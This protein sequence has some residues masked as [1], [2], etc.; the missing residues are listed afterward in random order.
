[1]INAAVAVFWVNANK[2]SNRIINS[3]KEGVKVTLLSRL[4]YLGGTCRFKMVM[5]AVITPLYL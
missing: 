4:E 1:M 3:I 5:A 2:D